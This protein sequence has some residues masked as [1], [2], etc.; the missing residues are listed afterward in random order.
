MDPQDIFKSMVGTFLMKSIGKTKAWTNTKACNNCN[1]AGKEKLIGDDVDAEMLCQHFGCAKQLIR[2]VLRVERSTM[3]FYSKEHSRMK[4]CIGYVVLCENG[5]IIQVLFFVMHKDIRQV[6]AY[7][8]VVQIENVSNLFQNAGHHISKVTPTNHMEV[9]DVS[10]IRKGVLFWCW[11]CRCQL[12]C[13][14][15]KIL[16][17]GVMK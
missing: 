10:S 11:R 8:N 4:K 9:V 13:Q 2:K 12:Y 7:G 14:I 5:L 3:Q 17:Y 6:Y 1:I 16:G 15:S